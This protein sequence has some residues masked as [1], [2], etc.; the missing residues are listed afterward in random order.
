M[1][2][3]FNNKIPDFVRY[4]NTI[5]FSKDILLDVFMAVVVEDSSEDSLFN[6]CHFNLICNFFLD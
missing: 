1:G 3:Y 5:V 6:F 2:S 4:S